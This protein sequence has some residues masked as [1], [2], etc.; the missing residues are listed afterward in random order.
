MITELIQGQIK[1]RG[2]NGPSG[3][4]GPTEWFVR[5]NDQLYRLAPA[6]TA[7]PILDSQIHIQTETLL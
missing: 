5:Y 4:L 6:F 1:L 2:D 3:E 7:P